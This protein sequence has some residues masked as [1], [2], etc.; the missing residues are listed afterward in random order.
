MTS[1]QW[2]LSPSWDIPQGAGVLLGH[3]ST[4]QGSQRK[5]GGPLRLSIHFPHSSAWRLTAMMIEKYLKKK[6]KRERAGGDVDETQEK[7]LVHVS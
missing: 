2:S 7:L 4:N 1:L 5:K 6:K 3:I